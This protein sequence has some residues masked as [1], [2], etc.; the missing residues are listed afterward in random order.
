MGNG[1]N[2]VGMDTNEGVDD[3]IEGD[4]EEKETSI[5]VCI[6]SFVLPNVKKFANL[7]RV[8]LLI[9]PRRQSKQTRA[10]NS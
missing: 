5:A 1:R 6:A 2:P 8:K 10:F 9:Y 3:V 4:K 7:L